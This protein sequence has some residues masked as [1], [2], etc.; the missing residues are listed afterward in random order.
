MPTW[1][2]RFPKSN[3][4]IHPLY[5]NI[6]RE[7]ILDFLRLHYA[8]MWECQFTILECLAFGGADEVLTP[9]TP[10][11]GNTPAWQSSVQWQDYILLNVLNLMPMVF[12]ASPCLLNHNSYFFSQVHLSLHTLILM[13]NSPFFNGLYL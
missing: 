10:W 9:L 1:P 3:W 11:M 4:I 2:W 6:C 7:H 5:G 13:G 8:S 12:S